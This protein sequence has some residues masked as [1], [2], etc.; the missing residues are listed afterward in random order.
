[1]PGVDLSM[2]G[3]ICVGAGVLALVLSL[4]LN[5]QATHTKHTAIVEHRDDV[6]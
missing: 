4:I 3:Y 2:V 6:A 5:A 1:M